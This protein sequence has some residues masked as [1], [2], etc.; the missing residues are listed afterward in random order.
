MEQTKQ[1]R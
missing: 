1:R